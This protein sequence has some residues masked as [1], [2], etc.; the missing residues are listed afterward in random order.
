MNSSLLDTSANA[1]VVRR[2]DA[3]LI[4]DFNAS[5]QA[6]LFAT[7]KQLQF[8]G[9]LVLTDCIGRE[10]AFYLHRGFIV[11]ATGGDHPVRRWKRNSAIYLPQQST[12]IAA[13][14]C[15]LANST[16]DFGS[17][18]QYQLLWLWVEQQHVTAEQAAR[19][20][21]S[22]IV[23]VLFDITQATQ[24]NC[25]LKPNH[26]LPKRFVLIDAG[27]AIAEVD[28]LWQAWKAAKMAE[29]SPNKV[30]VICETEDL[31]QRISAS[32]YQMLSQ[33]L[34]RQQTLREIALEMKRDV[35]T[36]LRS[37]LPYIQSGLVELRNTADLPTPL[38]SSPALP[39]TEEPLIACVDDSP[40]VAKEMEKILT[41]ANY[42]FVGLNDPLRAIGVLVAL[43][44]D[45][46]FLDLMM[47][48]TN[49]YEICGRLRKLTCFHYTPIVILTG[50]DGVI[51]RVRAKMVGS[52]DFLSKVTVDAKQVLGA[53]DK[54]LKQINL[55]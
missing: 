46:I 54:H 17:C 27:Q 31:R 40:W 10:W 18:W 7:L 38:F 22:D 23:E 32:A 43:K 4:R 26:S 35:L 51:D 41:A 47:P 6:E 21:W 3:P 49:G 33:L 50:N 39:E 11:Y 45:M 28:R 19:V 53:I 24:V 52:T 37:L 8:G 44:P 9:Q 12:D 29:Y 14:Q 48:N 20:V 15:E 36:L 2:N 25:E 34:E 13:L 55:T 5:N 42:R 1:L 30:P 16:D